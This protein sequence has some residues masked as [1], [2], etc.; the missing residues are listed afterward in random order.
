MPITFKVAKHE[1]APFTSL[2]KKDRVQ[3]KK[4]DIIAGNLNGVA[5]RVPNQNGFVGAV[6]EAYNNHRSLVLRPDDVWLATMIQFSFYLEKYAET[7]RKKFVDHEG[8]KELEVRIPGTLYTANYEYLATEM[9]SQIAAN[10]KDPSVRD[11][12][13]PDFTTTELADKVVGSV[14]LMA[15]MKKFFAYKFGLSCGIPDVTL[16]GEVDDWKRLAE[17]ARRIVEF[18]VDGKMVAWSKLL[19]PVLDKFVES[20][21]GK[22]DVEWWQ[23][24]CSKFGGG[25]GPRYLSGWITTFC[26]FKDNGEWVGSHLEVTDW[27]KNK[28]ATKCEHAPEGW[29]VIDTNDLP[30]GLVNVDVLVDDNGTP[31]KC[32]MMAGHRSYLIVD[33][34]SVQPRLEWDIHIKEENKKVD[35]Y[36]PRDAEL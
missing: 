27:C 7:L 25:S 15:S 31:Y 5:N 14:V 12:V 16:L 29:P 10:I 17:K 6:R 32:E 13:L 11:W 36:A 24:V 34:V 21:E 4:Y 9:S 18:D 2:D 20:A 33:N 23:R 22:A 3:E 1:P 8:Q 28:Y 26:V 19:F 35:P 30:P